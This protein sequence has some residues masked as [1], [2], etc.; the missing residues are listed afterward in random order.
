[1]MRT[2]PTKQV[3]LKLY[4]LHTYST[5]LTLK[6]ILKTKQNKKQKV[7]NHFLNN[8]LGFKWSIELAAMKK[9]KK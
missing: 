7:L 8:F 5:P 2:C 1:M 9:N 6:R 4:I 3:M